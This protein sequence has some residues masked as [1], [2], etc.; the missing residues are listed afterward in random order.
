[1]MIGVPGSGKSTFCRDHLADGEII[2]PDD[3]RRELTGDASDQSRNEEV[4]SLVRAALATHLTV[5]TTYVVVDATGASGRHRRELIQD[6]HF[7]GAKT[8]IGI[9]LI[10]PLQKCLH[11]NSLRSRVVPDDVIERM[12]RQLQADPPTRRDGFD[13]VLRFDQI[14]S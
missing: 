10:T 13:A 12:D 6:A 3:I 8:I 11:Y 5:P 4:F 1:M 2:C 14:R 9:H 7:F